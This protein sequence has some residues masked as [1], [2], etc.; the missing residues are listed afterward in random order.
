MFSEIN[1]DDTVC[2]SSGTFI[3]DGT[4]YRDTD[5]YEITL[6]E[7]SHLKWSAVGEFLVLLA[8]ID[9]GSGDCSDYTVLSNT[10]GPACDTVTTSCE[11][12]PG[13]YWLWIAPRAFG[14]TAPCRRYYVAWVEAGPA[15]PCCNVGMIPDEYPIEVEPGGQFGYTGFIRNPR[16]QPQSPDVWIMIDVPGYGILGPLYIIPDIYLD[17]GQAVGMHMRQDIPLYAPLG[18]YS[19]ISFCGDYPDDICDSASFQFTVIPDKFSNHRDFWDPSDGFNSPVLYEYSENI[20]SNAYPNPFNSTT[21]IPFF[22]P[23]ND[24]VVLEIYNLNGQLVETIADEYLNAGNHHVSWDASAISSGIYFC[25]LKTGNKAYT[26]RM[27]LLK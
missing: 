6:T 26:K 4:N 17:P 15:K 3:L 24:H 9:P 5:W 11:V 7:R 1:V 19:Y 2:G 22:L 18:E 14:I 10:H 8:I 12:G 23:T 20:L 27:M 25:R 16:N 21:K 13:T